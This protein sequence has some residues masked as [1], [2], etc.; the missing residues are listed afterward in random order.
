[1]ISFS[2]ETREAVSVLFFK[3]VSYRSR[4][5]RSRRAM[6][7]SLGDITYGEGEEVDYELSDVPDDE[8]APDD[9]DHIEDAPAAV[10]KRRRA[11]YSKDDSDL[12]PATRH[13]KG[14]MAALLCCCT[15]TAPRACRQ[16]GWP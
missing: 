5:A 1:M 6:P 4:R 16:L 13:K 8:N 3:Q 9:E 15:L 12:E 14:A 10:T 2:P 7:S 11:L